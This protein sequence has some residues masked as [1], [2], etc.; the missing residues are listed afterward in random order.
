MSSLIDRSLLS[1]PDAARR[2]GISRAGLYRQI[3]RGSLPLVKIG[4][5]SLVDPADLDRLV[6][7]AK[8][9]G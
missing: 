3:A 9:R 4:N 8:A 7:A 5:R 6:A 2:I 1:I